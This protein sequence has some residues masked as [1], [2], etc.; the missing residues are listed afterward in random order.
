V[1]E[2]SNG[3]GHNGLGFIA[4]ANYYHRFGLWET[5]GAVSYA[6]NVQSYLITYTTSYYNYNGNIHRRFWRAAQW[7]AAFNGSHNGFTNQPGA[8]NH[9]EV[10]STSLSMRRVS[11]SGNYAKANGTSVLT[12]NGIQP[13]PPTPGLPP[14]SFIVYNGT[15]YGGG[16]SLT[17]TARLTLSGTY[18]HTVSGTLSNSILS[19]NKTEIFASQLQYRFRRISLLAG[20]TQFTQ[21][22]SAVGTPAG[23]ESS[24]FVGVSRWINFF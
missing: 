14:G 23:R 17:P 3:Q 9:T 22:I 13:L 21:G 12:S 6:Q 20:Y 5:S 24:Y 1:I 19:N 4:N 2:S 8:N 10:Y 11:V 7:T 18:S 16:I 15:S